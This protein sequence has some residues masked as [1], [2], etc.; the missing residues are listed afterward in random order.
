MGTVD[1]TKEEVLPPVGLIARDGGWPRKSSGAQNTC[2][3]Y[4][5]TGLGG[6]STC[7]HT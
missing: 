4:V 6:S 5:V 1:A 2:V 3:T 7:T